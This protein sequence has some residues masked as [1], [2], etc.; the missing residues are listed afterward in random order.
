[1]YIYNMHIHMYTVNRLTTVQCFGQ[2]IIKQKK[3]KANGR[4]QFF[5]RCNDSV[6]PL[7]ISSSN[8][9]ACVMEPEDVGYWVSNKS[10][11]HACNG[12][13]SKLV[14][15]K[16]DV[17]IINV[18]QDFF[19]AVHPDDLNDLRALLKAA[20]EDGARFTTN[21]RV[22]CKDNA[23]LHIKACGGRFMNSDGSI[24]L[25]GTCVN[26]TNLKQLHEAD[27]KQMLH[28]Q[29]LCTKVAKCGTSC[30]AIR[31]AAFPNS[32]DI[33]PW[34]LGACFAQVGNFAQ[35]AYLLSSLL[36]ACTDGV[37]C[38][39]VCILLYCGACQMSTCVHLESLPYCMCC[40]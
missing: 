24:S 37:S 5:K 1:M 9:R 2:C 36:I 27:L 6:T 17:T 3:S 18:D 34:T 19:S 38:S 7:R 25:V 20:T 21:Y 16:H 22:V 32:T 29:A 11:A 23:V 35:R 26:T 12:Y 33:L 15:V 39:A 30:S 8:A 10:E 14:H 40:T 13:M 28:E 31:I 4:E